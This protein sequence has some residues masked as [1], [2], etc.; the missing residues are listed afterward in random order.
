MA[1]G[2][3]CLS[4]YACLHIRRPISFP[5]C[6]FSPDSCSS[7][8]FSFLCQ[9]KPIPF[10]TKSSSV[11]SSPCCQKCDLCARHQ[12]RPRQQRC[13]ARLVFPCWSIGLCTHKKS[14]FVAHIPAQ[15]QT[16]FCYCMR[17]TR[18]YSAVTCKLVSLTSSGVC[19]ST[20]I[21]RTCHCS[22]FGAWHC[23]NEVSAFASV[24]REGSAS[25]ASP[26][27]DLA[28]FL[29]QIINSFARILLEP[30]C[31]GSSSPKMSDVGLIW[32]ALSGLCLRL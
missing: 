28:Q 8:I 14:I 10:W 25:T 18:E 26:P 32:Q 24:M 21:G 7:S 11:T 6:W 3:E 12:W 29:V 17:N 16:C 23:L 2:Q 9:D 15:L 1:G 5:L 19:W 20:E 13:L 31:G 4:S 22:K 30:R 27:E